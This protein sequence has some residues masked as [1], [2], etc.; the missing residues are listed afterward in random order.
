MSHV[1]RKWS[2]PSP[3]PSSPLP[4]C[5][6]ASQA[7]LGSEV[8]ECGGAI[9]ARQVLVELIP[10]RLQATPVASAQAELGDVKAGGMRHVDHE[11]VGQDQQ[12]ILLGRSRRS[13]SSHRAG[14]S[15]PPWGPDHLLRGSTAQSK[16]SL[17]LGPPCPGNS[18][19]S[20]LTWASSS[21]MW[22]TLFQPKPT[23]LWSYWGQSCL[24]TT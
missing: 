15:P 2:V 11:G 7:P 5:P 1:G 10:Q 3:S 24:T 18:I 20:S 12:L 23:N 17:V 16:G 14:L 4:P 22:D 9:S 8:F 21:I 19:G 13:A 6:W